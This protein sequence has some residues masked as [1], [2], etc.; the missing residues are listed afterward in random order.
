[1]DQSEKYAGCM[2]VPTPSRARFPR[3]S[4]KPYVGSRSDA[5]R[6]VR[7]T[8]RIQIMERSNGTLPISRQ[9]LPVEDDLSESFGVSRNVVREAL[10]LLRR[11]GLIERIPGVG[12]LLTGSKL[13]QKL[14]EL[15]GLAESFE[16][17]HVAID[18][19]VLAGR[20]VQANALVA[21]KLGVEEGSN[22][23]FVERLRVVDG[24]PLSLDDSYLRTEVAQALLGADLFSKDL[25]S[26]LEDVQHTLLGWAEVTTEAVAA[27]PATADLLNVPA[28]SP[29]LLVQRLI[30]LDD[31]T[32][33]DLEVIRY[34]G[35][36]FYLS[37]TLQ[38][39]KESG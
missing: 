28:G 32:P 35:D 27:D 30:F 11:E 1:M 23:V 15:K 4:R 21:Q 22:V 38:R 29:L 37:S 20:E 5:A 31:G 12:T 9:S 25:F 33:L 24:V 7:D 6:W 16:V 34:R 3:P 2:E 18:N 10:D 17:Y 14:D 13:C 8:L 19:K 39:A 36:R 26:V